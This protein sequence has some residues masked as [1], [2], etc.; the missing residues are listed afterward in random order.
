MINPSDVSPF[1]LGNPDAEGD[2]HWDERALVT[3][4]GVL[5]RRLNVALGRNPRYPVGIGREDMQA[6]DAIMIKESTLFDGAVITS[7][8]HTHSWVREPSVIELEATWQV[9]QCACGAR[10]IR[11]H[12][13]H[14]DSPEDAGWQDPDL[15]LAARRKRLL[16][17]MPDEERSRDAERE[18]R[19]AAL[20]G[21]PSEPTDAQR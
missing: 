10:M 17:A 9:R 15:A 11:A 4:V 3:M 7:S 16:A 19:W 14:L 5:A 13:Y 1:L 21:F 20:L 6:A 2:V 18:A 12:S 8:A